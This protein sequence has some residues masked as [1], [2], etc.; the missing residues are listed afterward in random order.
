MASAMPNPS[1]ERTRFKQRSSLL[2]WCRRAAQ[3]TR[4]AAGHGS[5]DMSL[6]WRV[7]YL[8]VPD[9]QLV[10]VVTVTPHD[11]RRPLMSQFRP[12]KKRIT[13]SVGESVRIVRERPRPPGR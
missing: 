10:Q 2:A 5:L 13:V 9:Q 3:L 8:T 11:Y 12:A 7:I 6:Q 1:L 4:Y